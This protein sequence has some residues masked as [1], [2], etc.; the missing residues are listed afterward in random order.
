MAFLL[1]LPAVLCLWVLGAHFLRAGNLVLTVVCAALPLVLLIRRVWAVRIVQ[2]VLLLAM[3]E[4][5]ATA[6]DIYAARVREGRPAMR[7]AIIMGS[8]T[9]VNLLAVW[10]LQR[11]ARRRQLPGVAESTE[12]P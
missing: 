11:L 2:V 6:F 5:T 8:V 9:V 1:A 4:W 3:V 12:A 7:A 10:A